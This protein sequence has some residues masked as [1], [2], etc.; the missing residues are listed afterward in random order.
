MPEQVIFSVIILLYT[1]FFK[2]PAL[3]ARIRAPN[4]QFASDASDLVTISDESSF[5]LI[6]QS[7]KLSNV[8]VTCL[9]M[10]MKMLFLVNV[11]ILEYPSYGPRKSLN[12]ILTSGQEQWRTLETSQTR[13]ILPKILRIT[14]CLWWCMI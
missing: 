3:C 13:I 11:V 9:D 5:L 7:V 8:N 6:L 14:N 12:L 2:F 4:F 10:L 1:F